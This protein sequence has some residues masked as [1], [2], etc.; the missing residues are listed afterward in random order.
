MENVSRQYSFICNQNGFTISVIEGEALMNAINKIHNIGPHALDYYRKT[1]LSSMQMVNFL[2]PGENLGFYVD[3][4]EPF[5]RFKIEIHNSGAMRTLLLPEEFDDFPT[6]ITGKCRIHKM[7]AGKEPYTSI[8]ELEKK[9]VQEIVNEV[10]EKSYQTK[11]KII[12]L[13]NSNSSLMLTKLPPSN[14]N[15]KVEDFDDLSLEQIEEKFQNLINAALTI[16]NATVKDMDDLFSTKDLLYIGSKEVKFHC[17]CSHERMVGNLLTL[18]KQDQEG[19]F[20]DKDSV[21]TRCDY[22]N[23]IYEIKKEEVLKELH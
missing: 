13:P 11:S 21:E 5:F 10:M 7:V 23:T 2:K 12:M 18:P 17:P 1:V 22:C 6:E 4:E 16:P 19:I 14:V 9:P 20:S 8:L 15:K 3:S